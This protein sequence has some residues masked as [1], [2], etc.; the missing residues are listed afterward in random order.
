LLRPL[1]ERKHQGVFVHRTPLSHSIA[2]G[3]IEE[4][5][6]AAPRLRGEEKPVR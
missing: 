6:G 2:W 4:D 3:T 5:V 1:D